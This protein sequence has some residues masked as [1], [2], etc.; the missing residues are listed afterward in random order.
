MK[1]L[2]VYHMGLSE[3][4]K[5]F[6]YEYAK[7]GIDLTVIAPTE[8]IG[9]EGYL[10][11]LAY[12]PGEAAKYPYRIIPVDLRK[13]KSYGEGFRFFQLWSAVK[14]VNPDIIHVHDEYTSF[15][16]TQALLIRNFLYGKK[17]PVICYASQ[18]IASYFGSPKLVFNNP[19]RFIKRLARK[20]FYPWVVRFHANNIDGI[21]GC[22][23][24]AV[25][26]ARCQNLQIPGKRIFY[27]VN[28]DAFY[29]KDRLAS[30]KKL[31]MKEDGLVVGNI[32]RL[33]EQKG[34]DTLM[35]AASKLP[36]WQVLLLGRG[37]QQKALYRLVESQNLKNRFFHVERTEREN[38]ID[39]Y[40]SLDVFVIASRTMSDWKEQYGRVLAEAMACQLPIVGSSS[41]AIPEVL[42]GYPKHLIFKEDDYRDLAGKIQEAQ[43]MRFPE[44][45]N[46]AAFLH[47]YSVQN[48]VSEHILFYNQLLHGRL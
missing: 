31:G 40:N 2:V 23:N 6:F 10:S 7:Q 19:I 11:Q 30:R 42:E 21:T 29:K 5:S 48:F 13:A 41:G 45:F 22:S 43:K 9:G 27:G 33:D 14:K 20:L 46:I 4:A 3:D 25:D 1:V 36:D 32:G 47:R 8:L 39:Y 34:L 35:M 44:T 24:E 28:F 37:D 38:L 12:N 18:N 15:Y 17:V 16:L 26:L